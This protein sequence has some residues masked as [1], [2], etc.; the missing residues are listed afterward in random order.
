[1]RLPLTGSIATEE[2]SILLLYGW[3]CTLLLPKLSTLSGCIVE[4]ENLSVRVFSLACFLGQPKSLQSRNLFTNNLCLDFVVHRESVLPRGLLQPRLHSHVFRISGHRALLLW[5]QKRDPIAFI[6]NM[7]VAFV[8]NMYARNT[9]KKGPAPPR[10]GA[11]FQ[12]WASLPSSSS[13]QTVSIA[14]G[15]P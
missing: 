5:A 8:T 4:T 1:M 15:L 14:P 2:A 3:H 11:E 13:V 10:G 9:M 6:R 12:A 7:Y